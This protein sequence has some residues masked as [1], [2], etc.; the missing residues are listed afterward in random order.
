MQLNQSKES[1]KTNSLFRIKYNK[2]LY[3]KGRN[4]LN[5]INK[6]N[7]IN[8]I[9]KNIKKLNNIIIKNKKKNIGCQTY[10][11]FPYNTISENKYSL[12]KPELHKSK[13]ELCFDFWGS[14]L[15]R[16]PTENLNRKIINSKSY[17]SN[18]FQNDK[19]NINK[20]LAK[21]TNFLYYKNKYQITALPRGSKMSKYEIN[22]NLNFRKKNNIIYIYKMLNDYDLGVDYNK[23]TPILKHL[24][25]K[26]FP[27]KE[28]Y[29]RNKDFTNHD[30][31]NL[32]RKDEIKNR[33]IKLYRNRSALKSHI[34]FI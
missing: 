22:D 27:I 15:S 4:N 31:F 29:Y 3:I 1:L 2:Q 10:Y 33:Y 14:I 30:T 5:E 7:D 9:I 12:E 24:K 21:S 19:N 28:I 20:R 17:K 18:I 25:I 23:P 6:T 11:S 32:N 8:N 26:S 13:S 16:T 34:N